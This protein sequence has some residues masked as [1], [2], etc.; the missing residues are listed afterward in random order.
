M[1][2]KR[3]SSKRDRR[4]RG[5]ALAL[6]IAVLLANFACADG[7]SLADNGGMSG[8][9]ISDGAITSF[10]SIFVGGVR[11]DLSSAEIRVRDVVVRESALRVGMVVRVEGDFDPG[12][13][14]GRAIRVRFDPELRGP[15]ESTPVEVIPGLLKTFTLLGRTVTVNANRTTFGDGAD[16]A[17]LAADDVLEVSGLVDASGNVRATRVRAIPLIDDVELSD[18]VDNLTKNPDGSGIF[19]LGSITVRYTPATLFDDTTRVAL[20]NGDRVEVE[21]TLRS[22]D[23]VDASR[24]SAEDDDLGVTDLERAE[25]EGVVRVCP[26]APD[27]CVRGIRV[28]TSAAVFEPPTFSPAPGDRVEIEGRVVGGILL[29]D[30]VEDEE[31]ESPDARLEGAVT[32]TDASGGTLTLLGVTVRVDGDTI[33]RDDSSAEDESFTLPEIVVGDY[34]EVRGVEEG[35]DVRARLVRRED[36]TPGEDDVRLQGP[37]TALDRP[38]SS[39]SILVR[40]V[41]LDGDTLY[42]DR[43]DASRTAEEF[44][45]TP[46]DV[47]IGDIVSAEDEDAASLSTLTEVDEVAIED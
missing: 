2:T 40:S 26:S 47:M 12:N 3:D 42:F 32:A 45:R 37:V 11:W 17:T 18:T 46:G 29:A 8:T 36:A 31:D 14:T 9:G 41:P 6:L 5:G 43:F 19:D 33:L 4:T 15:I 27:F 30:R 34:L 35:G 1:T 16:F 21:G 38:T 44:F 25:I 23:E 28:D 10:G 39:L 7:D 24:I 13:R 20:A 22:A